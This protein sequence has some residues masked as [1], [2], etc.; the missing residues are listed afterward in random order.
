MIANHIHDALRQVDKLRCFVLEKKNFK[1]YSGKARIAGGVAAL[2]G[3]AAVHFFNVPDDPY[4]HFFVWC[5]VLTV[6]LL[7]NYGALF[8]W[9]FRE[10]ESKHEIMELIPAFDAVPALAAGAFVTAALPLRGEFSLLVP[11]WMFFYGLVHIP[12]RRNLPKSIYMVGIFYI[13]SGAAVLFCNVPFTNPWPMG[14]VFFI[15]ETAGGIA[16]INNRKQTQ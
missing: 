7:L 15:G 9:F 8:I 3:A 13:I 6:A 2:A 4:F 12:Y 1:G 11:L 14:V 5:G 10:S 16:L